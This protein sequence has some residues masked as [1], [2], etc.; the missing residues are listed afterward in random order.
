[1]RIINGNL[2]EILQILA[3]SRKSILF[4][5]YKNKKFVGYIYLDTNGFLISEYEY[6]KD[7]DALDNIILEQKLLEIE[8]IIEP[9]V[10]EDFN[11]RLKINIYDYF[12]N[13][14]FST[15]KF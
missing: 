14:I 13:N 1:M 10:K 6:Y 8:I 5:L 3:L 7:Y 12:F 11:S 9:I 2:E 15:L 4:N